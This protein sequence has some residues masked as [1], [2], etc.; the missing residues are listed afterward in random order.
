MVTA[1]GENFMFIALARPT[2]TLGDLAN[3]AYTFTKL[4][5]KVILRMGICPFPYC[6][7]TPSPQTLQGSSTNCFGIVRVAQ[8]HVG[9]GSREARQSSYPFCWFWRKLQNSSDSSW[10][11][12]HGWL[13]KFW[14]LHCYIFCIL[15]F[16]S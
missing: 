5:S 16:Y 10:T 13:S 15:T 1:E 2:S 11:L 9:S 3:G 6:L 14:S 12:T 8:G 7:N 4:S